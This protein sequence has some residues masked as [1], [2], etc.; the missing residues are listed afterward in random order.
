MLIEVMVGA[1]ILAITTTAVLNG[2]DGAQKT[3]GRNK[4]R[5]VAAALAE[6]DQ[7][8]MRSMPVADLLP[9]VATPYTPAGRGEGRQLHRGLERQLRDRPGR[10][11]HGL[12]G[13][14]Q[15]ADQPEDPVHGHL[16]AHARQRGPRRAGHAAGGAAGSP[17]DRAGS[18]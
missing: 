7:E 17:P 11:H 15:D 12:L 18:S 14:R 16:A 2:L 1:L 3:G 9:Y 8:R 4:A 5:S 6:Q 13:Q 10:R